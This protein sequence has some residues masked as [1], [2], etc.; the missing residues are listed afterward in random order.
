MKKIVRVCLV[1]FLSVFIA[2]SWVSAKEAP[3]KLDRMNWSERNYQVLNQFITDYGKGGKF[4]NAKK[5][6]YVVL[7]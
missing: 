5:T 2:G 1:L 7:D 6:R 3:K 4:Y